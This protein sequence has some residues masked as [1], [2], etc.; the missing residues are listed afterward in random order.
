MKVAIP[1]ETDPGEPRV[2]ATPD[3]VKRLAGL[4]AEVTV[5]AGA[6]GRAGIPDA[7]FTAAGAKVANGAAVKDA[8]IV[9]KVRR[10]G[11][12]ELAGLHQELLARAAASEMANKIHTILFKRRLPVD[13]RHNSKIERSHLAKWAA[14]QLSGPRSRSRRIVG[15]WDDAAWTSRGSR[16]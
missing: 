12:N 2:A 8:D 15:G 10:P 9:L 14:K 11:K 6:G 5:E 13:P 4:G 1:A 3:T 16:S 7:D